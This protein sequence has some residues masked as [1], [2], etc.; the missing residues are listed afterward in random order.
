MFL[1]FM[2]NPSVQ[3]DTLLEVVNV[4]G[5]FSLDEKCA[6][7]LVKEGLPDLLISVLKGRHRNRP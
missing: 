1:F 5:T 4:C 7:L 6:R 2:Q 3:D